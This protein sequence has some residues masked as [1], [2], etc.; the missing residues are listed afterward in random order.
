VEKPAGI[1]S[2]GDLDTPNIFKMVAAY[3]KEKSKGKLSV[4]VVHRLDKEVSGVLLF[5][6]TFQVM[7]AIKDNW[8]ENIK[9]YNA[10]VEGSPKEQEGEI[11]SW[12]KENSQ[13]LVYSTNEQADAKFAITHYRVLNKI[14]DY[15]LVEVRLETGRKNQI[16]VH[17]SDIGCP[18]VGDRKYGASDD[19][20]RRIRLH[21]CSLSLKHP[22]NGLQLKIE[23]SLP[24]SFLVIKQQ[25]ENYKVY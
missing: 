2:V 8:S 3:L 19:F 7:N 12:L 23:S 5:A 25:D 1:S 18:I 22:I 4:F 6:K 16:R 13:M 24:K 9:I 17:L 14:K 15:T 21:A 10:L 11:R 20:K